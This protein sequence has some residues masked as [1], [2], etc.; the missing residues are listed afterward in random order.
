MTTSRADWAH[1]GLFAGECESQVMD[2]FRSVAKISQASGP[3]PIDW[4]TVVEATKAGTS[5]GRLGLTGAETRAYRRDVVDA[6]AAVRSEANIPFELP[7]R[8][9]IH[10]R[11]HWIDANA[12]TF[13]RLLSPLA[14]RQPS[15]AP[16]VVRMV[17]TGSMTLTLSLLARHV[18]GQYDPIL[19]A[20][21]EDH[22]IYF[23]HPNII[24]VADGLDVEFGLF[25]RW[26]AF[27]EVTHAAE[28]AAAP[29]L[30]DH[31][32]T[33]V[34]EII[35]ELTRGRFDR[36][37][38]K[39]LDATMTAVEGYAELLMDEAF[40]EDPTELRA[41]LD[42][43]RRRLGPTRFILDRLL[44]LRIKRRQYE[45]GKAFFRQVA[46]TRGIEAAGLVWDDPN[47]LPAWEEF[48]E[49]HAWLERVDP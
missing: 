2:V 35:K 23:V 40:D 41:K 34:T 33:H 46:D 45:R 1:E 15:Q 9:E 11:H 14:E 7:D 27:H 29:W 44:G 36:S 6:R 10:N 13:R 31:L 21:S 42:A 12:A 20:E 22:A 19:L 24:R 16:A 49:P 17:N 37:T 39:E 18:L 47:N 30:G 38:I 4:D 8:L 3:D 43:R 32:E 28:F 5:P 48:D 26:I 25:R